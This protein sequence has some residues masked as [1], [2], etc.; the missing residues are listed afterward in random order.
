MKRMSL[1]VCVIA[2]NEEI[3]IARMLESCKWADQIVVCDTGSIDRTVEILNGYPNVECHK[4]YIWDD[5]F[6]SCQNHAKA[7]MKTDWILSLDCDE[8]LLSSEEEVRSAIELGEKYIRCFMIAEGS[9]RLEFNFSRLFRNTPDI[10]WCQ[11]IHKH[12]N[13]PGEGEAIGNVRI[14]FGYSPAHA[15]DPD[16]A[17]RILERVVAQ[18]G[19]AAGRN[20]Y[21]LGREYWYKQRYKE[22]TKT[23]GWY[24]QIANWPAEKAE[25][26]LI[27]AQCY[28]AQGLDEDAR[29]ACL[30]AIKINSNFKEAIEW[31]AGISTPANAAQWTRMSRTAN[32]QDVLWD[33]SPAKPVHDIIF[34]SP[35]ND[36]ETLYCSYT[37]MRYH[38]LVIV[39][40]DSHIQ[41][42]RGDLGCTAEIR[43]NETIKAMNLLGCPVLFIG[44]KDTELTEENLRERLKLLNPEIIYVPAIQGGNAQHDLVGKVGLELF[45]K[46]CER[47]TTYTKTDLYTTSNWEVKPT[48]TEMELKN[49]ALDCYESQL[50][51]RSTAPHFQ[52][53]RN[54][55]EWLV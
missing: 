31:M 33:R 30:Q 32:N 24:V 55:S 45:G 29:D 34:L 42:E 40:T 22:C 35:H 41:P 3:L 25:A 37:L 13:L 46:K 23:L 16:R 38:P 10:Y 39:I 43:R 36:D 8:V 26:F 53:V 1:G 17:L 9:S 21:Y 6:A 12:L 19:D 27:M 18:E 15:L 50:N 48:Q 44:I 14:M 5:D 20:L 7:K 49:K 51:L 54:R 4:D 2:K 28:S 11:P 52:A 47:Y